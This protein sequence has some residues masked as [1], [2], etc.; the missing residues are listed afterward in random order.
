[1]SREPNYGQTFVEKLRAYGFIGVHCRFYVNYLLEFDIHA[2]E[3]VDL[4][5]DSQK[6]DVIKRLE[7]LKKLI[8]DD[9]KTIRS[10]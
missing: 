3:F 4:L 2:R 9:I 5:D 6:L 8:D 1:M 10:M 7:S